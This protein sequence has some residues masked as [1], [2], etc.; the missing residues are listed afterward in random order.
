M[1]NGTIQKAAATKA[2][3]PKQRTLQDTIQIMLPQIARALPS[4]ITPERFSRIV[5]TALSSNPRLQECTQKS[6]LGAVMQCAALGLEPET[7]LGYAYLIPRRNKGTMECQLQIGYKGILELAYRSGEVTTVQCHTVYSEDEFSYSLGLEPCLKHVP[8]KSDRGEPTYF[9]A[10]WH[11]KN[12]GYGFE[13]MSVEDVQRHAAK[14]SDSYKSGYSSPW[15]TNFE[16]MAKKTVLR[17]ALKYA[18]LGA[19]FARAVSADETVKS[20]DIDTEI[21]DAP[22]EIVYEVDPSTGEVLTDNAEDSNIEHAENKEE[23]K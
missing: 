23:T 8:A 13:V 7:P 14:Y 2:V 4:T 15:K 21:L 5:L 22:N 12:G 10:V 6:F 18:P 1:T 20:G 16:E 3:A 11:T 9:Y 19:E 17:A